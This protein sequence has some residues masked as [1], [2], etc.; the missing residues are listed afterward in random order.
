M[1]WL[2][3]RAHDNGVFLVFSNGL[4]VDDNEIRAGALS[5]RKPMILDPCRRILTET[6]RTGGDKEQ[7]RVEVSTDTR[8][9]STRRPELYKPLTVPTG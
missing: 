1:R 5:A 6:W 7:G 4:G 9:I 2:P 8:W 3:A